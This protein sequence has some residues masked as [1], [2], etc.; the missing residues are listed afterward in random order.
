[1][2]DGLATVDYQ[3]YAVHVLRSLALTNG[4]L[5]QKNLDKIGGLVED[6]RP[7]LQTALMQLLVDANQ[8]QLLSTLVDHTDRLDV[9]SLALHLVSELGTISSQLLLSLFTKIGSQNIETVCTERCTVD[10]PVGPVQ[11]GRLTNTWNSAAVN[12]TVI[13]HIQ[14]LPLPQW[15]VEFALCKLLLKQP[16]DSTS[17]QIWQQLFSQ[18]APQ[19]GELMRD[20]DMT[21][22]IFDI[23]GFYLVATTDIELLERLQPALEP[24]VSV[25][26]ERCKVACTKFLT[27]VAELGPR[28]KQVVNTLILV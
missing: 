22:V 14:N 20:E 24:V 5:F 11:L 9:L 3:P 27:T 18:L 17:A 13:G 2:N 19:I 25:A 4:A 21:E 16:M 12:S 15:N 7:A 8:E 26:K 10:S 1:V 28:F 6:P 23:V